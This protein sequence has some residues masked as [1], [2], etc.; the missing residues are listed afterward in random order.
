[1]LSIQFYAGTKIANIAEIKLF[2]IYFPAIIATFI[3][4]FVFIFEYT[5]LK[6]YYYILDIRINAVVVIHHVTKT[7][8]PIF[9]VHV[10][11]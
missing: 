1:M 10:Y 9:P 2:S 5:L 7:K 4:R 11:L 8:E 3:V 6:S